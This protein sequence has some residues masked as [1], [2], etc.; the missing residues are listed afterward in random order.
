MKPNGGSAYPHLFSPFQ[1][2]SRRLKN[3]IVHAAMATGYQSGGR[4][5]D[6]LIDYH[7]TRARGGT[8]ISVTEPLG[9]LARQRN[10]GRVAV[11]AENLPDLSRWAQAVAAHDCLLIAQIQDDGRG[12]HEEGRTG[13]PVGASPLPD[14]LSWTVPHPMSEAEIQALIAEFIQSALVL[15]DAGWAGVE[16]SAGHGHIFHQFLSKA[17]NQRQDRYGGDLEGRALLLIELIHGLHAACGPD[18]VIGV[19]LPGEDGVPGGVDLEQAAAVT[20]L[21]HATGCASYITYCWGAHADTLDWHLPDLHGPRTPF[22]K[23]IRDLGRGGA[24]GIALGALGLITDPNEGE[25][26]VRDGDADLVMMGRPLV[27]DPA[28]GVKAAEG[29]ESEIRYCVSCNTCWHLITTGGVLA[30]DNNPRVG[31]RA[32]ADWRPAPADRPRRVVVVGAGPAGMEA[33][34]IA[35]ARGHKVTVLG[36]SAEVGGKARLHALLPGG[37]NLSSVYDHQRLA[38]DR[39]GVE[40][41]LGRT[42]DLKAIMDLEPEAVVLAT[43]ST[44]DWPAF[45]PAEFKEEG[46][47]PDIRQAVAIFA[48]S[49]ARQSGTAVLYDHDHTAFTYA[50][51]QF[52]KARFDRLV[53]ITPRERLAHSE[54]LVTR[55]SVYRRLARD[56]IEFVTLAEPLASSAFEEGVVAYVDTYTGRVAQ[57]SDVALVTFATSRVPNDGL[58]APLRGQGLD[59][60]LVGDCYAP[61]W[62]L[63]ATA[64]GARAGAEV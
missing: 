45:L 60:R 49:V 26:I 16:I 28:W 31:F 25:R 7:V 63:N 18:F 48:N 35:A 41:T 38:A 55:Q 9:M 54:S 27:A 13:A 62:L 24:P 8:A 14:D 17:A 1:L 2:G 56:G 43:G 39:F 57:V 36:A 58:A 15:R 40:L 32:E 20:A 37:E 53:L 6:R 3:R 44:P 51:A 22:V 23:K 42:A 29:R 50:A 59:V 5:T 61:R 52:L 47:F 34:W 12:R 11:V 46:V 4:V 10:G 64:E 30:C 19:K 21:V 33:A